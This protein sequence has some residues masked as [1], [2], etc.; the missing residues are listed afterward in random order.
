M[1][2][3]VLAAAVDGP[4]VSRVWQVWGAI[5]LELLYL[6][7]ALMEV[8]LIAPVVL[9]IMR[10]AR[11]WPSGQ[12]ALW[13]LLLMLLPFNLV[14][15]LSALEIERKYQWRVVLVVL[16]ATLLLAWRLLLFYPWSVLDLSW[17][18]DLFGNIGAS[19]GPL[20]GRALTVFLIVLFMWWRGLSLVQ[21]HPD[22]DGVG[23]RLRAG[24]LIF[25]PIILLPLGRESAWGVMPFVLLYFVAGLMA[26]ALIRAEQ[27][28]RERSGF[29]AS[30]SP[31]WV[32][33]IFITSL[34]VI[35][36]S[37]L[38]AI[39]I[40]GDT[41][42]LIVGW[43]SPLRSALLAGTAV[44][45]GTVFYLASPLLL[46]FEFLLIWLT[47]FFAAIFTGLSARLGFMMPQNLGG[48]D[49]LLPTPEE[50]AEVTG[51]S[52]P[53]EVTQGLTILIMLAVV[54]FAAFILTRRFRQPA[55][56]P[57][58]GAHIGA[59][60]RSELPGEGIG[61]RLL[62]RL[63]FF[64]RW[65]TA[66]S[67]RH[68]YRQMCHA[69]S[70]AGYARS[71]SETPYEYLNTLAQVWPDKQPDS[72]LITEAYVRVRYGEIPENKEELEAIRET[73]RR[74]EETN[75]EEASLSEL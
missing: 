25:V 18:A 23:L 72:L 3:T 73:W 29:A 11:F 58:A 62:Q 54:V 51:I 21:F 48:L 75:P 28:E 57:R 6:C 36:T 41:L 27:V 46:L 16:L 4:P 52:I 64:R 39:I 55:L 49:E 56:G 42:A 69:A 43:F 44:A 15:F 1:S 31:G 63:G 12:I 33:T 66:A 45:I 50:T 40:S 8:A 61:Q 59:A 37:G 67:I 20:W 24:I 47:E 14:R 38:I 30:L 9:F 5:K 2:E 22:I 71:P 74:L 35:M 68:I 7:W 32:G 13:I 60:G 34:L 10:W 19:S 17:L 70:G 26:I 53:M 65:Q